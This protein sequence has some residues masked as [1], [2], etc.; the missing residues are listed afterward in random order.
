M[1]F[2]NPKVGIS[3]KDRTHCGELKNFVPNTARAKR[4]SLKKSKSTVI[5]ER[6]QF[7]LMFDHAIT[8]HKFQGRILPYM[9][10]ELN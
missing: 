9:Q 6:K 3:L 8:V 4:F 7:Q 5:S 10:D 2:D 1:K